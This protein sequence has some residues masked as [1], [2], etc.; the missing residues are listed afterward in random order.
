RLGKTQRP[1]GT[2]MSPRA[3]IVAG[4][5]RS[6]SLPAKRMEPCVARSTPEIVRLSV[7]FPAPFEPSTA[8]ISSAATS[9]SIPRSTSIAPERGVSPLTASSASNMCASWGR[10]TCRRAVAEISFDHARIAHNDL[11]RPFSDDTPLREHENVFREAHHRLHHVLGHQYGDAGVGDAADDRHHRGDLG[12]VEAGKHLVEQK[13]FGLGRER[14]CDF[15]PLAARD[16][17]ACGWTVE[18]IAEADR[19][20]DFRGRVKRVGTRASRQMRADGDVLVHGEAGERL[21]DLECAHDAAP[22]HKMGRH[23]RYVGAAVK[24]AAFARRQEPADDGEQRGLAGAVGSDQRGDPA[25]FDGERNIVDGEE[26][27]ET[28][29]YA[30]NA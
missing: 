24:D 18:E 20:C 29:E 2:W 22:R 4:F 12:G 21:H 30:L 23:A 26:A 6:I 14:A 16:G 28:F 1:S 17:E 13:E 27:A 15:Q 5:S 11:R 10:K 8:T 3:T 25:G 19:A 9:R 7:D